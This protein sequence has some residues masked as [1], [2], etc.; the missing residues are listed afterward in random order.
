MCVEQIVRF[1]SI[2]MVD[3]DV[4]AYVCGQAT[5]NFPDS[6]AFKCVIAAIPQYQAQNR[7]QKKEPGSTSSNT[8]QN[9]SSIERGFGVVSHFNSF[10]HVH[11]YVCTV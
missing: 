7:L 4:S 2:S 9:H 10:H 8:E 5:E 3:E 11:G 1:A 6:V